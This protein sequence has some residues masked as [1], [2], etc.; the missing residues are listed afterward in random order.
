MTVLAHR[1]T[2]KDWYYLIG[3]SIVPVVNVLKNGMPIERKYW[4][5]VP[6]YVRI[7]TIGSRFAMILVRNSSGIEME[8]WIKRPVLQNI[9]I[10]PQLTIPL[11]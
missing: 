11:Q 4:Q 9:E 1:D 5:L 3:G 7:K 10:D 6:G 2:R 8:L